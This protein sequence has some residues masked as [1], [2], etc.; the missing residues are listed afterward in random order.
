M[1]VIFVRVD[2]RV[3]V[4][5]SGRGD[6]VWVAV[7]VGCGRYRV[8]PEERLILSIKQFAFMICWISIPFS[9]ASESR[10]SP[11]RT[12]NFTQPGV[13]GQ[14][15]L[16]G[17]V[18]ATTSSGFLVGGGVGVV[19]KEKKGSD[20][21]LCGVSVASLAA[22]S[23]MPSVIARVMAPKTSR[24]VEKAEANPTKA[25]RKILI[26]FLLP[27]HWLPWDALAAAR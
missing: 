3:T 18:V 27:P 9:T 14:V 17:W 25:S 10:V 19:R 11:G 23:T 7:A 4:G 20:D 26:Q 15:G 8:V 1:Q 2:V 16:A 12:G 21:S 13:T 5:V 6:A 24:L 22:G